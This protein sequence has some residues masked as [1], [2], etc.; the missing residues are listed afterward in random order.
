MLA[1]TRPTA[2]PSL[3]TTTA[4]ADVGNRRVQK[5]A[6]SRIASSILPAPSHIPSTWVARAKALGFVPAHDP[7]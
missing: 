1:L 6:R 7:D 4:L 5:C 3:S 2:T